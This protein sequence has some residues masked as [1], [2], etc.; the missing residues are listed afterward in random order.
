MTNGFITNINYEMLQAYDDDINNN[1]H[2]L[3]LA[4]K[5]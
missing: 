3:S 5:F 4:L 2:V 1:K